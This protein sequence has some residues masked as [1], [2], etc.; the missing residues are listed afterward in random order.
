MTQ[1]FATTALVQAA[2]GYKELRIS[3]R[4]HGEADPFALIAVGTMHDTPDPLAAFGWRIVGDLE[5][6]AGPNEERAEVE[7]C[8]PADHGGAETLRNRVRR[9][10][11]ARSIA[12][13]QHPT[14]AHFHAVQLNGDASRDPIGW[15]FLAGQGDAR[16][17]T[18]VTADGHL[19]DGPG[20]NT[21]AEATRRVRYAHMMQLEPSPAA[22][23]ATRHLDR[24]TG[25]QLAK[26]LLTVRN[27]APATLGD[28]GQEEAEAPAALYRRGDRVVCADGVTRTVEGMAPA[29]TGE[30][31]RV[32]VEGGAEWI[33]ENCRRVNR[34]DVLDA[35]RRAHDAARRLRAGLPGRVEQRIIA[36]EILGALDVLRD[37]DPA[38]RATL[39]EDAARQ[40]AKLVHADACG[41][42]AIHN[43]GDGEP[44][45]W[46][47]RTGHGAG[48]RYG[49]VTRTAEVS[50]VGL[51]EYRTTA[52]R[53]FHQHEE[54]HGPR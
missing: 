30:P 37:I 7:P 36:D 28:E 21:R 3:I 35:Y 2:P 31:A 22:A 51:Y 39:A 53:A 48:S 17:Y 18:W 29:V 25:P 13:L 11:R 44:V 42:Q 40:A 46:T 14:A 12:I 6:V 19:H 49:V 33:A 1:Y 32:V 23:T 50:P 9:E 34:E 26:L 52:E 27:G 8:E 16:F 15:T 47:F 41:F 43:E 5:Y 4:R 10:I 20:E 54:E 24:M 45:A 38:V